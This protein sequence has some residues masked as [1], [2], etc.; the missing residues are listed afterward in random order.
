MQWSKGR[1]TPANARTSTASASPSMPASSSQANRA[2]RSARPRSAH[3][4]AQV[5]AATNHHPLPARPRRRPHRHRNPGRTTRRH[6]RHRR[7]YARQPHGDIAATTSLTPTRTSLGLA[8]GIDSCNDTDEY[9]NPRSTTGPTPASY[10]WHVT[11][12][13]SADAPDGLILMQASVFL[14]QPRPLLQGLAH[15]GGVA[16]RGVDVDAAAGAD[17][18]A[19]AVRLP[20]R[21]RFDLLPCPDGLPGRR[22]G[23]RLRLVPPSPRDAP[24]PAR[25]AGVP[26]RYH[27]PRLR[28]NENRPGSLTRRFTLP[29]R[30]LGG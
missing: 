7:G 12:E 3:P 19:E 1:A 26:R 2:A 10:G 8:T 28:G 5:P 29:R 27:S 15:L 21:L 16:A 18:S 9:G 30:C 11:A 6:R 22:D 17:L 25:A 20:S 23:G 14:R 13:R 4:E 24:A